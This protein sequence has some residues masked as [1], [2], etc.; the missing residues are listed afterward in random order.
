MSEYV[1]RNW[2]VSAPARPSRSIAKVALTKRQDA[3]VKAPLFSGLP[4]RQLRSIAELTVVTTYPEGTEIVKEGSIGSGLFVILDGQARVLK[5]DRTV[6][7]LSA[8]S[9]FGEVSL[10]DPGPRTATVVAETP[11]QCLDLAGRDLVD[12]LASDPVL[13][14]RIMREMA[15]RLRQSEKPLIA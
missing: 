15:R 14:M 9:F 10:L 4:K 6:A 1:T 3:L 5:K 8:G 11:V 2:P 7:R 13:A 12:V